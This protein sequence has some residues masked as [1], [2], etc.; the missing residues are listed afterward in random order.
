MRTLACRPVLSFAFALSTIL[1]SFAHAGDAGCDGKQMFGRIA[2]AVDGAS[3]RL[4]DGRV[5]RLATVIA[6]LPIDGDPESVARA[7]AVLAEIANGKDATVFF[8]SDAADRYGRLS[9]SAVMLEGKQW[10]E[11]ALLARGV[12]RVYQA[13]NEKC[14]KALLAHEEKARAEAAGFWREA[15]FRVFEAEETD[16]L[17]AAA[18]RFAV[19]EG[20]IRRVGEARGRLY[21]DFGRRFTEDFTVIVPDNLRKNFA[22]RGSDPKSWRGKRIR[23]RGILFSWGGPAME[24]NLVQAIE[25]LGQDPLKSE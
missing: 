10:L 22:Q 19:V 8:S 13:Q 16:L 24:I 25:F 20:T 5:I 11:A 4:A 7:K 23:V 2:E 21:L 17:H 14:M 18:G 9:A 15:K 1:F 6:P 12:V 3:L